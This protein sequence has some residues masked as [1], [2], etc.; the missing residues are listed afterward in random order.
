[1]SSR[2][3]PRLSR[4]TAPRRTVKITIAR[5]ADFPCPETA[6]VRSLAEVRRFA[7]S[8]RFPFLIKPRHQR[9]WKDLAPA[10]L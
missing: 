8:A 9:E 3:G 7:E 2:C 4:P 5:S 10:T 6:Y 1:M